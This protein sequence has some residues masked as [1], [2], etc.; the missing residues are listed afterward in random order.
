MPMRATEGRHSC[1]HRPPGKRVERSMRPSYGRASPATARALVAKLAPFDPM[2]IEEPI[3]GDDLNSLINLQ[4]LSTVP[5]AT[6]E[7]L[8]RLR[9]NPIIHTPRCWGTDWHTTP[10]SSGCKFPTSRSV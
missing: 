5:I 6:G 1:L 7:R 2:F 8:C 3:L 9:R 10:S 4:M